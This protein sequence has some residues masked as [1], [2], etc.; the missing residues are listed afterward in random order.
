LQD[1]AI[2]DEIVKFVINSPVEANIR[3]ATFIAGMQAQKS[4]EQNCDKNPAADNV[5]QAGPTDALG[6]EYYNYPLP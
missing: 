2:K 6:Q 1:R 5:L 4:I 3:I